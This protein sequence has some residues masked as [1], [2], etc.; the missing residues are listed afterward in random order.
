MLKMAP[1]LLIGLAFFS[2]SRSEPR[3]AFGYIA[4]VYYEEE[5]GAEERFSFFVLA[6]DDDGLANLS[7][8][9]LYHDH[10]Q[11]RWRIGSEDWTV[12]ESAGRTWIGTRAIAPGE[13]GLLPRGQFRAVLV[14]LG[15]ERTERL[16]SFDAPTAP[17]FAFPA[18]QI[19]D[20]NFSIE[21]AYPTNSFV[22]YDEQGNFVGVVELSA[23]SGSISSLNLPNGARLVALWAEDSLHYTSAFTNA[24]SIR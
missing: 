6:E 5:G 8:L 12:H 23:L 13:I 15:G 1:I 2:C 20:G 11:L 24:Q 18:L 19:A 9:F 16:F 22:C 7:E 10:E 14:N 21:S 3:I 4:L 17:R